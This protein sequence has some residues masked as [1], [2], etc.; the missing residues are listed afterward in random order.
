MVVVFA[1]TVAAIMTNT[2]V[3][4]AL[5]DITDHFEMSGALSG[6]P[7]A[8]AA[9][10]GI[11]LALAVGVLA[12]RF[13]R[14]PVLV[15]C[16][17]LFGGF[18]TACAAAPSFWVL[19]ALRVGQGI[20]TAGLMN[21]A[22]VLIG[23]RWSGRERVR[24]I[25]WNAAVL[26]LGIA[27]LPVIGGWLAEVGSWRTP[28]LLS[29]YGIG[30]AVVAQLVL[31]APRGRLAI[32]VRAQLRQARPHLTDPT[33]VIAVSIGAVL[34]ALVFGLTL[35]TLPEHL[36]EEFGI[37]AGGRGLVLLGHAVLSTTVILLLPRIHRRLGRNITVVVGTAVY[38]AGALMVAA[39][40]D[41]GVVVAAA[42]SAGL[43]E[44]LIIPTL[45]DYVAE[46]PPEA[47]RGVVVAL[48]TTGARLGQT[49]GPLLAA[50]A[51]AAT[52]TRTTF[53]LGAVIS[54]GLAAFA[55]SRRARLPA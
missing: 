17:L 49:V 35:G 30:V 34:F 10:P 40:T 1:T 8:A 24:R 28:F 43:A 19:L 37:A 26:T 29:G 5:P 41:V 31:P 15:T 11:F 42:S 16:L 25:S 47:S 50:V 18:G 4:A 51:I 3:V 20:G 52:S 14:R 45:Q 21:L 9:L 55:L 27:I 46:G 13:G 2:V 6:L 23:D 32:G 53:A 44:G 12:D 33:V 48:F 36:S 54:V 38:A 39:A 22:I 7:V